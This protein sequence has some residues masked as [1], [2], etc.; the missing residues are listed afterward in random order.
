[1]YLNEGWD[2]VSIL[3]GSG[4]VHDFAKFEGEEVT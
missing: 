1:M 2:K 4:S 3:K